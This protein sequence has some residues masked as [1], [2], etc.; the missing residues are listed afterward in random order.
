[1][2]VLRIREAK[3][4]PESLPVAATMSN[5]AS[6]T[7]SLGRFAEADVM[8]KEVLRVYELKCGHESTEVADTLNNIA[9]MYSAP[10]PSAPTVFRY[11]MTPR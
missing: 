9:C 10:A 1:M 8:F 2:E 3:L 7:W 4:G 6:L 11:R 5:L